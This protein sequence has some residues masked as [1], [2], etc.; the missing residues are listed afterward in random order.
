MDYVLLGSQ[1]LDVNSVLD[2][3]EKIFGHPHQTEEKS[4]CPKQQLRS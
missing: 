4:S 2:E 3:A 1:I